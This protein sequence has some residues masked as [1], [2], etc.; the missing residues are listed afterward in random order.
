MW[1]LSGELHVERCLFSPWSR[2][3]GPVVALSILLS[4][5]GWKVRDEEGRHLKGSFS[6]RAPCSA[7]LSSFCFSSESLFWHCCWQGRGSQKHGSQ[8]CV[9]ELCLVGKLA[10]V[11]H[12]HAK[13]PHTDCHQRPV[14]IPVTSGTAGLFVVICWELEQWYHPKGES[15]RFDGANIWVEICDFWLRSVMCPTGCHRSH[16]TGGQLCRV[17]WGPSSPYGL[18]NS[19]SLSPSGKHDSGRKNCVHLETA[20]AC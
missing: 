9:G 15:Q 3:C 5:R 4:H 2:S 7:I 16:P 20:P 17:L 12:Q 14:T 18:K 19:P 13:Y 8:N 10:A 1:W 11:R 6:R